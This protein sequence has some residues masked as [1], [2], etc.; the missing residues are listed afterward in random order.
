MNCPNGFRKKN[1][2]AGMTSGTGEH[3]LSVV[4][5][6]SAWASGASHCAASRP[7]L[8]PDFQLVR[9]AA[10]WRGARLLFEATRSL[11]V[12][13]KP[14]CVAA[15]I[16]FCRGATLLV[17]WGTNRKSGRHSRRH[18]TR[19]ATGGAGRADQRGTPDSP[20]AASSRGCRTAPGD[21]RRRRLPAF[22]EV[23]P[24]FVD[25]HRCLLFF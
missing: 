21:P 2:A 8:A 1:T 16:K 12:D 11:T 20:A 13:S 24:L 19:G 7:Q 6:G 14:T 17:A 22:V 10:V 25:Q 5:G 9:R 4:P 18:P 3:I 15:Q 23:T